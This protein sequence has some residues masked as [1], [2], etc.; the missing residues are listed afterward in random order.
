V[1]ESIAR[2]LLELGMR[3]P[4]WRPLKRRKWDRAI[5]AVAMRMMFD[6]VLAQMTA[7]AKA[8]VLSAVGRTDAREVN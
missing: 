2:I 6:A 4:W 3:P 5:K 1:S 7:R 8:A